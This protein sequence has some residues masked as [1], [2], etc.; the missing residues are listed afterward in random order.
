M[1][2]L[3]YVKFKLK[4]VKLKYVKLKYVKLKLKLLNFK[5]KCVKFKFKICKFQIKY[6][7]LYMKKYKLQLTNTYWVR[8]TQVV[9]TKQSTNMVY[10]FRF[11]TDEKMRS[12][13]FI[14][15]KLLSLDTCMQWNF[16]TR[17]FIQVHITITAW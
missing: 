17:N 12:C 14:P 11:R 1:F 6:I 10:I 4:Y 5:L 15:N 13:H 2:R 9:W 16:K 3:K 7:K 8:H